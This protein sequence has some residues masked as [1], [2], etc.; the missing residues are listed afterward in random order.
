M[1][2]KMI[3]KGLLILSMAGAL[4]FSTGHAFAADAP[5]V[6]EASN[7][8]K[9]G[10]IQIDS[11]LF[12]ASLGVVDNKEAAQER[13]QAEVSEEKARK[14][15]R[16]RAKKAAKKWESKQKGQAVVAY[17][18]KFLGNPYVYGGTSLTHG[19][20]CSG[21][22]RGVYS[23]FGISLPHSSYA[24]RSVGHAVS[25]SEIQPG[26]IVCYPGHVG[27][28]AGNGQIINAIGDKDG[29]G[30]SNAKYTNIIT[31]RRIF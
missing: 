14:A 20:D 15:L 8:E 16:Q 29:I 27:I 25:Y 18:R 6:H 17:A 5:L 28:Y 13:T 7:Q 19:T 12:A 4:I 9:T 30:Y 31:I 1:N 3:K 11:K 26:D 22:V 24:Q 23:H 21:Y 10:N 2:L